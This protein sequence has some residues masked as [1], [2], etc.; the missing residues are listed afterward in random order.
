MLITSGLRAQF[1]Y[2]FKTGVPVL[3]SADSLAFP[4]VGGLNMPQYNTLDLDNDGN[5][6]VVIF[7]RSINKIFTFLNT[8]S[9]FE[10]QPEYERYFPDDLSNWVLLR[11]YNCDGKEDIFT[12]SVFGMSLYENVTPPNGYPT[13]DLVYPTI[14]TEGASG[15]INLQVNSGDLPSI[16]D[17]DEDGD[18][19]ILVF[20][21]A[22]GGGIQFHKN[23]SIDNSG[24]C[25]LDL[26]LIT[27]RY[28][29]F[30]ECTCD[31]YIFGTEVCLPS[32]RVE[33]SG[34][35]SIA[36]FDYFNRGVQDILIGQENC[37]ALGYLRNN[38][39][40][41]KA[42]MDS[43]S[44]LFPNVDDPV[45]L[46]FPAIYNIDLDFDGVKDVLAT[47][48]IFSTSATTNYAQNN[49]M[50]RNEGG[51]Y[52]L[53]TKSFLQE[54]MIDVGYGAVPAF[55]D[56]DLDGDEDLI[57]ADGKQIGG[58]GLQLYR[59]IGDILN[60]VFS[61]EDEDLLNIRADNIDRV[62]AQL[63]DVDANGM[64]DIL[65]VTKGT[66][67]VSVFVFPH[68]GNALNPYNTTNKFELS[69]PIF[70]SF[71][72]PH[73]Y[74]SSGK[75][76]L[77]IGKEGGSLMK[78]I[79]RGSLQNPQWEL[80]SDTYLGLTEDFTR[81][82][83]SVVND[84]MDGDGKND[85]VTYD[86]SGILR[87]YSDHN[88][89]AEL[90]EELMF[91][92]QTLVQFNHSFGNRAIPVTTR[93]T[94]AKLPSICLGMYAGGLSLL[95]NIND[96]QQQVEVPVRLVVYPNPVEKS[97]RLKLSAN[98]DVAVRITD[99]MGKVLTEPIN[100][101]KGA[102]LQLNLL[103]LRSGIYLAEAIDSNGHGTT[104]RFMVVE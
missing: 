36:S 98:K 101:T 28:G 35:K 76:V 11:D 62:Q 69:V 89:A 73:F 50:Y 85:L 10:Y 15:P 4:W 34:G 41:I 96:E 80:L 43:V 88:G 92:E 22:A 75:L 63:L 40:L 58:A 51:S 9:K 67:S 29:D 3:E 90:H 81:R 79:N 21:F 53:V 87:I 78:Y 33:H 49:W 31:T 65:L 1:Q 59:N 64:P 44:F 5:D 17:V 60:P 86:D 104:I 39:T 95:S 23:L 48:N 47:S 55:A 6:D 32:G 42:K 72:N 61:W 77:L 57:L 84:D 100:L 19:D 26:K 102:S 74:T 12:S 94:G 16:E 14:Y 38:G 2:F 82:N 27:E 46:E 8:G 7:D 37:T 103:H 66:S 99:V 71:D 25:G 54:K 68:T 91:D 56:I 45:T 97:E 24:V 13:W 93:L 20:D 18:L 70:S 83:L 52:A 30:E